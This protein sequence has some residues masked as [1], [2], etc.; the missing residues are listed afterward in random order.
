MPYATKNLLLPKRTQFFQSAY[1]GDPPLK[2]PGNKNCKLRR[3]NYLKLDEIKI[4]VT[5][6]GKKVFLINR[7]NQ[8]INK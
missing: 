8:R 1:R 4:K 7:L 3:K 6:S 5:N 2:L